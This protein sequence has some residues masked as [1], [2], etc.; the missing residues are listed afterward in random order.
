MPDAR[1][2]IP[3]KHWFDSQLQ[4]AKD[5]IAAGDSAG[6]RAILTALPAH[7]GGAMG[8]LTAAGVPRRL[9]AVL[10]RLARAE[11]ARAEAL[12][13]QVTQGPPPEAPAPA[14]RLSAGEIAHAR[15]MATLPVPRV[16]HQI[17]I[18]QKPVPVNIARWQAHAAQSGWQHRLWREADLAALAIDRDP[19][20]RAM[21]EARDYPGA[22][23]V[24][25]YAILAA[26]GG[27]YLDADWFP[28][29]GTLETRVPLIGL[30][31]LAEAAPRLT[32]A[33]AVMLGNYMIGAP[34]GHPAMTALARAVPEAMR[35]IPRAPAWWV[36]GPV[37]FTMVARQCPLSLPPMGTVAPDLPDT[38]T[39]AEAE[40]TASAT[41]ALMFTWK[42]W[43]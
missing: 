13:W 20:F 8:P 33:G 27:V 7:D 4:T 29:Q 11:G 39:L 21:L 1:D 24:A 6:A 32:G 5:A 41:D 30:I 25:R 35:L 28:A 3:E 22:V 36:S 37:I 15:E 14:A 23:D 9:H 19:A 43:R 26:E 38:A 18:G 42:S 34:A 31:A 40:A 2:M 17:W 16:L 10:G 12:G